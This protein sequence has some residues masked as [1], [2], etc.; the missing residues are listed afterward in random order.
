MTSKY[1]LIA[2]DLIDQESDRV[3]Y[4]IDIV[5]SFAQAA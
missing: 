3:N 5:N 2:H 4:Q 1:H